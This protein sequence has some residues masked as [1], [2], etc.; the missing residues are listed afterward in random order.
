MNES[1]P[2]RPPLATIICIY[3][4]ATA[5]IPLPV[6]WIVSWSWF[7]SLS[8]PPNLFLLW[9]S[10]IPL[11][12]CAL[13]LAGTIALWQ[14]RRSAFFLLAARFALSLAIL[15]IHLPRSTALLHRMSATMPRAITD[16][17]ETRVI[18]ALIADQWILDAAIVWY[19]YRIT[20]PQQ[21]SAELEHFHVRCIVITGETLRQ[22][23]D[24]EIVWRRS[25]SQVA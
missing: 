19:V 22:T 13:A 2:T 25:A 9:L 6:M 8:Y 23:D 24:G 3:L 10:P 20:A 14:M 12:I 16:S 18:F 4:V 5:F 1:R 7:H 17:L 11:V 15:V 21:V